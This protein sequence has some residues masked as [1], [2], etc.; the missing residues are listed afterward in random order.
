MAQAIKT[1]HAGGNLRAS[2]H[3]FPSTYTPAH[4]LQRKARQIVLRAT[5]RGCIGWP[6]AM[7]NKIGGAA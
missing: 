2:A 1:T 3:S 5:V 4:S 7:L 6:V